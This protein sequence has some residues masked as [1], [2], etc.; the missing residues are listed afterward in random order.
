M[1]REDYGADLKKMKVL[2]F[3][4]DDD[5][6]HGVYMFACHKNNMWWTCFFCSRTHVMAVTVSRVNHFPEVAMA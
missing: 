3:W 6:Y 2:S 1:K 4:S 5:R